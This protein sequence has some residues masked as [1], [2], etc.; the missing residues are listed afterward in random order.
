V[1]KKNPDRKRITSF[2]DFFIG[3]ESFHEIR[4]KV[5][6]LQ[7]IFLSGNPV[8]TQTEIVRHYPAWMPIENKNSDSDAGRDYS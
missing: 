8:R 5:A 3:N 7:A 1:I 4:M 2:R 6:C